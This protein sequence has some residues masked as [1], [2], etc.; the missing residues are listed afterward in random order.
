MK[1]TS[2]ENDAEKARFDP[3]PTD[4][5]LDE[6]ISENVDSSL[7]LSPS[8]TDTSKSSFASEFIKE[9]IKDLLIEDGVHSLPHVANMTEE[10]DDIIRDSVN[11]N[12][13]R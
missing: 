9:T 1:K 7:E 10:I 2:I 5:L 6:R 12:Q 4:R 11:L 8:P 13:L 3:P